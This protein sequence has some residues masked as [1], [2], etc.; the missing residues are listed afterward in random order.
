M[1]PNQGLSLHGLSQHF[2]AFSSGPAAHGLGTGQEIDVALFLTTECTYSDIFYWRWH[3]GCPGQKEGVFVDYLE[4]SE[5][6]DMR[7]AS[8]LVN[9][10]SLW[11]VCLE[12]HV[13]TAFLVDHFCSQS[14]QCCGFC[15]LLLFLL[16]LLFFFDH[17][18]T[19]NAFPPRS[20]LSLACA[21]RV[22]WFETAKT[23]GS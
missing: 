3:H 1:H 8:K 17:L 22:A 10:P 5:V 12:E 18:F 11:I 23:T 16:V 2:N 9:L 20:S 14:C 15:R 7:Q 13:P 21:A 4:F 19:R 6:K